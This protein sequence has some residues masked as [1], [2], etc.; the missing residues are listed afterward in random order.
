MSYR[1]NTYGQYQWDVYWF[2]LNL[3]GDIVAVYNKTGVKLVSY[4][5]D[6]WGK[7]TATYSN[8]G[9][10][11]SAVKN[12]LRYRGYYLD[13]DLGL[14][15]LQS[16]YYDPNTYRFINADCYLSTG[17]GI[18]GYNMYAY[19]G[20]NPVNCVDYGGNSPWLIVAAFLLFTPAGGQISQ[21]VTSSACYVGFA[22][23]AIFDEEVREDMNTI[24]W[25]PF[26]SDVD[27]VAESKHV[28][29][30]K[31]MPI[32]RTDGNSAS[33]G[34]IMLSRDDI[35]GDNGFVWKPQ[36]ILKHEYG[37]SIQQMTMGPI[38]YLV[39]IGIPSIFIDN[40]DDAPWEISADVYGGV[41]RQYSVDAINKGL[42]YMSWWRVITP[43]WWW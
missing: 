31:G 16:R 5:Y 6:P 21:A 27:V 19:C 24:G 13:S 12:N 14:Y 17:Q 26:N 25:N 2:D 20:N 32:F 11:T 43:F 1:E 18:L 4:S 28:S 8:G 30:Y 15:Y 36:D 7:C 34:I 22:I 38:P 33:V 23:T 29:F 9:A 35:K 41:N 39:N 10:S 42:N 3:Q 40:S 37:H